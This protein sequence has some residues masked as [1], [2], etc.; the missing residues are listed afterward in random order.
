VWGTD[1]AAGAWGFGADL[2][3]GEANPSLSIRWHWLEALAWV[4]V[5]TGGSDVGRRDLRCG[6]GPNL[7]AGASGG[8]WRSTAGHNGVSVRW[9]IG[10]C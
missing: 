4:V 9:W 5:R 6:H 7:R 1:I 10:V 2:S 8:G 3:V